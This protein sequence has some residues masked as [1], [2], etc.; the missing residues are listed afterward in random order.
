M[1]IFRNNNKNKKR[2]ITFRFKDC[3]PNS[4]LVLPEFHCG[5]SIDLIML[6]VLD[7][8]NLRI[9]EHTTIPPLSKKKAKPSGCGINN[10]LTFNA[11]INQ[12]KQKNFNRVER[13]PID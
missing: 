9:G 4:H 13:K 5:L 3:T 8:F 6:Y 7:T 11:L 12:G 10:R 2:S 1:D